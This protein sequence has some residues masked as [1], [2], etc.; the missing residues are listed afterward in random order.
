MDTDIERERKYDIIVFG[1]TGY[2]GQFVAEELYRLQK[3][4]SGRLRW[5]AAGRNRTKVANGLNG[6]L[7][8]YN[9]NTH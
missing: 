6:K 8:S 3:E 7:A 1:S 9:F 2:T 4:G 5:G